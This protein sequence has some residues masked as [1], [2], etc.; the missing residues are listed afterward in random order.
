MITKHIKHLHKNKHV[1]IL[2]AI[3]LGLLLYAGLNVWV[4]RYAKEGGQKSASSGTPQQNQTSAS[5]S[6][7]E[8]IRDAAKSSAGE[9]KKIGGPSPNPTPIHIDTGKSIAPG[10]TPAPSRGAPTPTPT[11]LQGPGTYACSKEGVCNAYSDQARK[12]FC[13]VT[14]ADPT[15]QGQC[16]D[17]AKR[18]TK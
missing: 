8:R 6:L 16:G 17:T 9:L 18:C 1:L 15:C 13:T 11:P 12:D 14:Y 10:F 5:P 2:G 7:I 3:V 4:F